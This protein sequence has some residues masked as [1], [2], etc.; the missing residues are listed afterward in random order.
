MHSRALLVGGLLLNL[1]ACEPAPGTGDSPTNDASPPAIGEA[2]AGAGPEPRSIELRMLPKVPDAVDATGPEVWGW[3]DGNGENVFSVTYADREDPDGTEG[4][5]K[6]RSMLIT[7]DV[8]GPDG[9]AERKR[10][11]KDFIHDCL[12]D[13]HLGLEEGSIQI[14]DLDDDGVAE[15]TF[16][17]RLGCA[18]DVSPIGRKVVLLEDGTKYILRGHTGVNL[19]STAVPSE[20]E[21]DPLVARGPSAFRDHVVAAWGG[22]APKWP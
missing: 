19:G 13:V 17:Y 22:T 16:A 9:T 18:S 15:V 12:F 5:T 10:T 6:S 7:H 2:V 14:S 21:A 8:I 11:V 4:P 20:Y 3:S 1:A